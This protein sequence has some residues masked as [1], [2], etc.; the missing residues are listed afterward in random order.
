MDRPSDHPHRLVELIEE[1]R[2]ANVDI[3]RI[4]PDPQFR[5]LLRAG[6]DNGVVARWSGIEERHRVEAEEIGVGRGIGTRGGRLGWGPAVVQKHRR[7]E[8]QQHRHGACGD[9]CEALA[10]CAVE[11]CHELRHDDR[12]SRLERADVG[13]HGV[14]IHAGGGDAR[15]LDLLRGRGKHAG[16]EREARKSDS[17]HDAPPRRSCRGDVRARIK[18]RRRGRFC[19]VGKPKRFPLLQLGCKAIGSGAQDKTFQSLAR[20]T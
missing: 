19:Q 6:D 17:Q 16:G 7:I 5:H 15:A 4:G 12:F 1:R 18:Y 20:S 14:P 13:G 11:P 9:I 8:R 10:G 2:A 3:D